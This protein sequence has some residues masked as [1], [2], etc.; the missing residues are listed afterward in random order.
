MKIPGAILL[1][2]SALCAQQL[3]DGE[4][5]VK[6]MGA[7][8]FR[9]IRYT[10]VT[11]TETTTQMGP[12][13]ATVESS[14]AKVNPGKSR[15]EVNVQGVRML[16]VSDGASTWTYS[17][18]NNA[19]VKIPAALGPT[20]Q[21]KSMG[22]QMPDFSDLHIAYKTLRAETVE[23]DGVK[24]DCWVV[25]A[26][27]GG[28]EIAPMAQAPEMKM[29]IKDADF[30]YW[31][32]QKLALQLQM[33]LSMTM[34]IASMPP[35]STHMKT[36]KRDV[37]IDQPVPDSMFTFTP[38]EGAKEVNELRMFSGSMPKAELAG[39][40]APAFDVKGLDGKSYSLASL[41]GKPMLLDFWATWCGPCRNSMPAVEKIAGEYKDLTVLAINVGEERDVVEEFLKHN[42]LPYA[43]ALSG[44]SGILEAYKIRAYATFVLIG[45]DSKVAAEEIG[46][47]G[48]QVLRAML[49]KAGLKAPAA[50]AAK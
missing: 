17:S 21:L 25:A 19:Y 37:K 31:I 43:A 38:P 35:V 46:F 44:D 3:P 26:H 13:K 29:K 41:K 30:T 6:Q 20:E 23:V 42:P 16:I 10:N 15:S 33:D 27:F 1:L 28:M 14:I 12:M 39:K 2:I 34:E 32:D 24:H 47:G 8:R 11:T 4:A 50:G 48:E 5:L 22:L 40:D 49:P 9:S 18:M 45:A 7:D 36:V